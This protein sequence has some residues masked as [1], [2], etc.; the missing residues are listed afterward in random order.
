M[1]HFEIPNVL[2]CRKARA[3]LTA[4]KIGSQRTRERLSK[5]ERAMDMFVGPD[6]NKNIML[7]VAVVVITALAILY[8]VGWL[9]GL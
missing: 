9:P 1:A 6:R 3:P 5:R 8:A 4:V 2:I 7:V